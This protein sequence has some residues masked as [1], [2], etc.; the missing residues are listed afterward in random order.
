MIPVEAT[1]QTIAEIL[2]GGEVTVVC[3]RSFRQPPQIL[4]GVELGRIRRQ[5]MKL[6]AVA[7][8]LDPLLNQSRV[9][10]AHVIEDH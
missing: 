7:V 4:D 2:E 10:I 9:V 3:R 8:G 6:N 5:E 1:E